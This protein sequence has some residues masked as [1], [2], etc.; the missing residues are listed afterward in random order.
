MNLDRVERLVWMA[1]SA[2]VALVWA[3][4]SVLAVTGGPVSVQ[5][6]ALTGAT[7]VYEVTHEDF[8]ET[9][10]NTAETVVLMNVEAKMGVEVIAVEMTEDFLESGNT[11]HNSSAITVGDGGD[12]DRF[13]ASMELN[14]NGSEVDLKYG[15]G[16][17][18]AYTTSDTVD[19]VLTPSTNDA[20]SELTQGKIKVWLKIFD[21]R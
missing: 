10:T 5:T 6:A 18:L 20:P 19:L 16:T 7:H 17:S 11:N 3:P 12:V 13:L 2:A 1:L 14:Q 9:S 4:V 21:A 15:T 8:T